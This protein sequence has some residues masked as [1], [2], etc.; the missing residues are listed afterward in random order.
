MFT[1]MR[2]TF[3]LI[4]AFISFTAF[5]QNLNG[6]WRGTLTQGPGGCFPVYNIEL[7]I[8]SDGAKIGGVSYHYSDVTN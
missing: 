7:N 2:A 8:N 1:A 5:S 3:L 4:A 6:V